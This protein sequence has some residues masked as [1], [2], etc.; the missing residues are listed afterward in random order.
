MNEHNQT[1][2]IRSPPKRKTSPLSCIIVVTVSL[3][4][5]RLACLAAGMLQC[6]PLFLALRHRPLLSC[7]CFACYP[8]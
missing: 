2:L 8:A 3:R 7:N 6:L 5:L 1:I 4:L